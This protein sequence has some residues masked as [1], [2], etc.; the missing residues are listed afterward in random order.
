MLFVRFRYLE[1]RYP[2]NFEKLNVVN[3]SPLLAEISFCFLND[4]KEETYLIEPKTL[5][6]EPNQQEVCKST[7]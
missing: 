3:T 2:D 5:T 6:L 4:V 1:F 7:K